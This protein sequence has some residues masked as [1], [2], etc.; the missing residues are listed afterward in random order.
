MVNVFLELEL[1][2][3]TV[4]YSMKSRGYA[5][6]E[7]RTKD[8]FMRRGKPEGGWLTLNRGFKTR[9]DFCFD[10]I[11]ETG[12]HSWHCSVMSS[13]DDKNR[14]QTAIVF[15]TEGSRILYGRMDVRD[16]GGKCLGWAFCGYLRP[17]IFICS[18][19]GSLHGLRMGKILWYTLVNG[20]QTG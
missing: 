11:E 1:E 9:E 15:S 2:F 13:A 12:Q 3:L 20:T 14:V 17:T 5:T 7:Y 18:G 6:L 10:I 8:E 19:K 4:S 16:V